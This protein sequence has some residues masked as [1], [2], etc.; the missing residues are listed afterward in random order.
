MSSCSRS[1]NVL[2]YLMGELNEDD[3]ALFEKHLETCHV[4]RHELKLERVLQNGLV[5]CTLPDAAPMGLRLKVLSRIPTVRQPRFPFWQIAVTLLSG[6][7][8]FLA[9]LQILRG[10]NLPETGIGLLTDLI[11]GAFETIEKAD[12]LPLMISA[13]IVLVGI[14][15][16]VA[17]LVPEE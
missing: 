7:A 10:S 6:A 16:V 11:G 12:S 15:T 13:G 4:C 5:E 8:A 2:S 1:N 14:V 3:K 9:L 17:S